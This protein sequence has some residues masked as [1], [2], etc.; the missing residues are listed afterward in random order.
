MPV[1]GFLFAT[2]A[3]ASSVGDVWKGLNETGF[4]EGRNVLSETRAN[5]DSSRLPE[6]AADLVKRQVSVIYAGGGAV[7]ARAAQA[8]TSTIPIVFS[9]GADPVATGLVTSLN[10]PGGNITGTAFLS[11]ELGAKRLSLLHELVPQASRYAALVNPDAPGTDALLAELRAAAASMGKQIEI[12][13][14]SKVGEIDP[15]FVAL[16]ERGAEALVVGSSSLLNGQGVKLAALAADHRLPVIYYDRRIVEVGGLMSYGASIPEAQREAGVYIGRI[17]K[18]AKPADLPVTQ[19]TKFDFVVNLKT[20]KALGL[21]I[22]QTLLATAD[23]V[24]E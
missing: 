21:T 17:L 4:V 7:A 19:M 6:L 2:S 5:D 23:E 20:A 12:F 14:A 15:A 8:A 1:V 24:I 9:M 3:A 10:R 13:T 16:V 18:G 22:P 11:N